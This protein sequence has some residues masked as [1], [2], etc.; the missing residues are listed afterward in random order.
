MPSVVM[1]M[2]GWRTRAVLDRCNVVADDDVREAARRLQAATGRHG[3]VRDEID[4][5]GAEDSK[6]PRS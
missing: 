2:G 1:R 6:A 4:G 3:R 5:G